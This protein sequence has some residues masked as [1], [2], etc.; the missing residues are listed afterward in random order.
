M[1]IY[2]K[3]KNILKKYLPKKIYL[4]I[5]KIK[6]LYITNQFKKLTTEETFKKIYEEKIWEY[7][8]R[9]KYCS[10]GGSHNLKIIIPYINIISDFLN[11][12]NKPIVIDAG[13]GDFNLGKNFVKFCRKYFAIDIYDKLIEYNRKKFKLNNLEFLTKDIT[14][15][16]LPDGDILI[17]RQVLQ[18]LSNKEII[19]FLKNI[20]NKYNYFIVVE[21]LPKGNFK[22]NID[23]IHQG[24]TRTIYNSGVVLH[25][26]PFNLTYKKKHDMLEVDAHPEIG[27]IKTTLY[28]IR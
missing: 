19:N 11:T 27:I 12:K 16:K 14:K 7:G 2:K 10:G 3:I 5:L 17:V 25:H 4:F 18:H 9:Q 22:S 23:M 26:H 28:L 21:H 15:D 24:G 6:N 20:K 13:C 1:D 8:D